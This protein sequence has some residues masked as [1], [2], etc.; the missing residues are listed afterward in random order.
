MSIIRVP[1]NVQPQVPVGIDWSNPITQGLLSCFLPV[2]SGFYDAAKVIPN[3]ISGSAA[4]PSVGIKGRNLDFNATGYL[5]V[6]DSTNPAYNLSGELTLLALVS[7]DN[8]SGGT[9]GQYPLGSGNTGATA[10]QGALRIKSKVGAAFG[11]YIVDG[12]TTLVSGGT[13][14]CGFRRS[15]SSGAWGGD[16]LLDGKSDGTISTASDPSAQQVFSIGSCGGTSSY[17]LPFDGKI[18]A[19]LVWKRAISLNEFKN[20]YDNPWQICQPLTRR[21]FVDVGVGSPDV[22]RPLTGAESTTGSGILSPGLELAL[23]GTSVATSAGT[24]TATIGI[25]VALTGSE[26]TASAGTLSTQA[27]VALSGG[28]A[29]VSAGM[30]TAVADGSTT[31][32]LSGASASFATGTIGAAFDTALTGA[33]SSVASGTLSVLGE[34][35]LTAADL[36]AIDALIVARLSAIAD[37][38]LAASVETGA[39]VAESLRLLNAVLGGKVSGAGTGTETFRDLADT[40]DRVVVTVDSS[41]NRTAITLDLD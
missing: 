4:S 5:Q 10:S 31:V 33:S 39:T 30:I 7:P 18:Y 3:L 24:V 41:G 17:G 12:A 6:A 38:V 9:Y 25:N 23:S 36:A 28:V 26:V 40:T 8:A 21:I 22:T 14:L 16:I 29:T 35:T 34:T 1:W 13:Y 15:G 2:G 32:A 37:A 11:S 20:F 27:S 19:A